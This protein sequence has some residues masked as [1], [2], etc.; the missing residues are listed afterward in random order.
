MKKEKILAIGLTAS[1]VLQMNVFASS[2]ESFSDLPNDWSRKPLIHAV[3]NGLISGSN[4][5]I[6]GSGKLTRAEMAAIV[7]RAFGVEDGLSLN[8]FID[9]NEDAWYYKDMAKA[10][11]MEIIQGDNNKLNP[12][13]NITREEAFTILARAFLMEN[14]HGDKL[15]TFQ[16]GNEVSSW[17]IDAIN[18]LI[19]NGYISG[20]EGKINPR[21]TITRAEFAKVMENLASTYITSSGT[22]SEVKSGN[23]IIKSS[24]VILKDL[25]ID[26]DLIFADGVNQDKV[27]LDNVKVAGRLIIRGGAN[28]SEIK[29]SKISEGI[30]IKNNNKLT[31]LIVKDSDIPKIITRT[32]F[33]IDGNTDKL[34]ILDQATV[35]IKSGEVKDIVVD[36]KSD[37]TKIIVEKEG[38]VKN[39]DD[40]GNGIKVS[41]EGRK[42][43]ENKIVASKSEDVKNDSKSRSGSGGGRSS[44]KTS[45]GSGGSSSGTD[46]S[47]NK[48]G[49]GNTSGNDN[50]SNNTG[51]NSSTETGKDKN[52]ETTDGT[53]DSVNNGGTGNTSG[54]DNGSNNTGGNSSTETG[55][56]KNKE[57]TEF[58]N[59]DETK[60]MDLGW[61]QYT[62][63]SFKNG[64]LNDYKI[65]VNGKEVK[66][67]K[68]D[69]EGTL[70]KW[71][72]EKLGEFKLTV[73]KDGKVQTVVLGGRR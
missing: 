55:K 72:I 2:T 18:A 65:S 13:K 33:A 48:G 44:S 53:D 21:E 34:E 69:D 6:N 8:G 10:V 4:G 16:D 19:S 12:E 47:V 67:S 49:T 51:G 43:S 24:G 73:E 62:V 23:V 56:D 25:N 27:V 26:G 3:E 70:A 14:N 40:N 41:G 11:K 64:N 37:K 45:S 1:M 58:L 28:S 15:N 17:A 59:L 7:S 9:V 30:T 63:I 38:Y 50:G 61:V 22:I 35:T 54:N 5:K 20:S 66:A 42:N 46:D 29:S 36:K 68:I 52:K 39:I 32:D 60:V 31:H 57:T 71:E